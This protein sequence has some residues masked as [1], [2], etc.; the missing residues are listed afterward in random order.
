[1]YKLSFLIVLMLLFQLPKHLSS[2]ELKPST[3]IGFNLNGGVNIDYYTEDDR[4]GNS[5]HG[6]ENFDLSNLYLVLF[7]QKNNIIGGLDWGIKYGYHSF[8]NKYQKFG[9]NDGT[10]KNADVKSF[11]S[12]ENLGTEIQGQMI[13][14]TPTIYYQF[15]R[16]SPLSVVLGLGVGAAFVQAKGTMYITDK[17]AES[18]SDVN[19]CSEYLANSDSKENV[20]DY[21][22]KVNISYSRITSTFS[23]HIAILSEN[24]GFEYSFVAISP[25]EQDNAKIIFAAP[26]LAIFYQ[27]YF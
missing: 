16:N 13:Y 9:L 19:A 15:F 8:H 12:D 1:M 18:T 3:R 2:A 27:I 25:Q 10:S 17:F 14:A 7:A 4:V 24:F 22:E 11:N 5:H 26:V 6:W 20:S 21:C 23:P